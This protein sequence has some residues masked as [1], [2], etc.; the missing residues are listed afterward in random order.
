MSCHRRDTTR[1]GAWRVSCARDC[2]EQRVTQTPCRNVYTV[3]HTMQ[4]VYIRYHHDNVIETVIFNDQSRTRSYLHDEL[5][6]RTAP[7]LPTHWWHTHLS[8]PSTQ[9]CSC[10]FVSGRT[11]VYRSHYK[12]PKFPAK[13]DFGGPNYN[14]QRLM[15]RLMLT[16]PAGLCWRLDRP[17]RTPSTCVA[18]QLQHCVYTVSTN[19]RVYYNDQRH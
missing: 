5:N 14:L 12:R 1:G 7:S 16:G 19:K 3:I 11:V 8:L 6:L 4:T 18:W 13:I 17:N 15:L 9:C 10:L 2:R